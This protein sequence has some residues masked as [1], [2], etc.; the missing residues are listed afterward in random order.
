MSAYPTPKG[1]PPKPDAQRRRRNKPASYGAAEPVVT[2]QAQR[3]PP[4]GF[5]AHPLVTD[6]WAALADS[7]ESDFHSA[8]DWQRAR[9]EMFYANELLQGGVPSANQWTSLQHG[10]NELL[11]SPAIKRR[12][13]IELKRASDAD[14]DAAVSMTAKYQQKLKSV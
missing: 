6:L 12:A 4:L 7:V 2:G 13:G 11:L 5:D 8:V 9:M 3:Q 14:A 1:V 10:L